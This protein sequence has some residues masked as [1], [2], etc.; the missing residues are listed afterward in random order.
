M[1][2]CG[3][4]TDAQSA[5]S[6]FVIAQHGEVRVQIVVNP[7][8][9][10][11]GELG[12]LLQHYLH[13]AVG[14]RPEIV[15]EERAT[16]ELNQIHIGNTPSGGQHASLVHGLDKEGFVLQY[17]EPNKLIIL[18]GGEMGLEYGV[19]DFLQRFVGVRWLFAGDL[20]TEVPFNPFLT[21]VPYPVVEEPAFLSRRLSDNHLWGNF[22]EPS[23][24]NQRTDV[25]VWARRNRERGRVDFGHSLG[26]RI[27]EPEVYGET[28]PE[29][30]PVIDNERLIPVGGARG[31]AKGGG[32]QPC[33]THPMTLKLGKEIVLDALRQQ[34]FAWPTFSLGVNDREGYCMCER[35]RMLDG[36]RRNYI[37]KMDRSPSYFTWANQI[38]QAAK[39]EFPEV[40]LGFLAYDGVAEPPRDMEVHPAL[41]PYITS[42]RMKWA[43]P[44]LRERDQWIHRMWQDAV[45]EVG[46]YDYLFG[47]QYKV[48]RVYFRLM[49]EYLRWGYSNGVR[50]FY[51]EAYPSEDWHEGPKFSLTLA[52]LWNPF[53]DV[54]DFLKDWYVSA[55][56]AEAAIALEEYFI[57]WETYWTQVIPHTS[58]FQGLGRTQYFI[59]RNVGYLASLSSEN[60]DYLEGLADRIEASASEDKQARATF[61]A[62]S[63][64][65]RMASIRGIVRLNESALLY[66]PGRDE[67]I[68]LQDNFDAYDRGWSV[69]TRAH[70]RVTPSIVDQWDG[71]RGILKM[72]MKEAHESPVHLMRRF[73]IQ[74]GKLYRVVFRAKGI[75]LQDDPVSLSVSFRDKEGKNLDNLDIRSEPVYLSSDIWQEVKLLF[76]LPDDFAPEAD[77]FRVHFSLSGPKQGIMLLDSFVIAVSTPED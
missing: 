58:W 13:K 7:E 34:S 71:E 52:L 11:V 59:A 10:R 40:Q 73:D 37:H 24:G 64:H 18:G 69:W 45:P 54:D 67:R 47:R 23:P 46:W 72:D 19:Y 41:V 3:L 27:F 63:I 9:E 1:T 17:V 70:G 28:Y 15:S 42:D 66:V 68:L 35:C 26:R 75:Q 62:R 32:W 38:A 2:S 33:F 55:V 60:L 77:S 74:R 20:G 12:K 21:I 4:W 36:E 44:L 31:T 61:I 16:S 22:M 30:F 65:E 43:D 76:F 39:E 51:A 56:G 50:Y 53:L 25:G 6:E 8:D 49:A 14:G 29:I 48:P 5:Q 57:F